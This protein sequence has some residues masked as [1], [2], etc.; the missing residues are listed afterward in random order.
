MVA[1]PCKSHEM[2]L[3]SKCMCMLIREALG[4]VLLDIMQEFGPVLDKQTIVKFKH[5]Q[6]SERRSTLITRLQ[7]TKSRERTGLK[8]RLKQ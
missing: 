7:A 8:V 6:L 4:Q 5:C 2:C 3:V 1:S